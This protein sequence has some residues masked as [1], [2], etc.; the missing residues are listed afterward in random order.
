MKAELA[1]V[2][3]FIGIVTGQGLVGCNQQQEAEPY[4]EEVRAVVTLNGCSGD[5]CQTGFV[6]VTPGP[7]QGRA[8]TLYRL[9][10]ER[11]DTITLKAH[12]DYSDGTVCDN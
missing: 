5:G 6:I 8:C 2:F 3:A 9:L 7:I 10:G 1:L 4:Y 12:Y 11:G